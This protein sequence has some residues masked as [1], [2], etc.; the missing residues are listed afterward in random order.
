MRIAR[1]GDA[2]KTVEPRIVAPDAVQESRPLEQRADESNDFVGDRRRHA[3]S[4]T[5]RND[6]ST[7]VL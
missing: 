7:V 6:I 3:F 5:W 4:T 2:R 1:L